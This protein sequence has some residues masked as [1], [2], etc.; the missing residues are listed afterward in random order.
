MRKFAILA[1]AL[2]FSGSAFAADMAVKA[3]P[4]PPPLAYNWT[5]AYIGANIG[6]GWSDRNVNYSPNDPLAAALFGGAAGAPPAASLKDSGVLGGLQLGYNWRFNRNWLVGLETDFDWSGVKGSVSSG[7]VAGGVSPFTNTVSER[8]D[9]F[10]T[11][12]ARLGYLPTNNLLT[13][14]TGGFAYG[15]IH[16]TGNYAGGGIITGNLAGFGFFCPGGGVTCF[17]GSSGSTDIGWTVGAGFEYALW[18]NV[19]FKAEYLYV[20]LN[21]KS[22]T[23]TALN[24]NG[25][26]LPSSFNAN[27]NN[28]AFSVARAGFNYRF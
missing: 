6:G 16:T 23:E 21:G 8:V 4:A 19:T 14:I 9:W 5:G 11:A 24:P 13:Y 25:N 27:F 28:M 17:S 10:G 1:A 3:P 20:S 22:I 2:A 7:G 15:R 26:A 12:R 18:Q